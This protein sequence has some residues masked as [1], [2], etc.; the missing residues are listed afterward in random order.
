MLF[1][2]FQSSVTLFAC[3]IAVCLVGARLKPMQWFGVASIVFGGIPPTP[4]PLVSRVLLSAPT[5]LCSH[6]RRSHAH[7]HPEAPSRA[8][9]LLLGLQL[10]H[11][12]LVAARHLVCICNR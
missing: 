7:F 10:S 4:S 3:M 6:T 8:S 12:G 1:T 11:G 9:F 5:P 2:I